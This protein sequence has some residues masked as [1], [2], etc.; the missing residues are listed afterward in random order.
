M[1][2]RIITICLYAVLFTPLLIW[3]KFLFPFITPKTIYFRCL[4]EIALFFY[5]L[6]I[7]KY[8]QYRPRLNPL[9][10]AVLIYVFVITIASIFGVN[11]YRSFWG[12][13]ERGEGLLTIYHIIIFFILL[14]ALFK[15]KK[16]WLRFFDISVLVSLLVSL[17]ALAQKLNFS[18]VVHPG[19]G[20][21]MSTIGNPSFVAAYLL[22]NI[23]LCLLLY[24]NKKDIQWRT[25]YGA[26][27]FFEI[28]ILFNTQ[29]RGALLGL[30]GGFLLLA[31]LNVIF[32]QN[33]KVKLGFVGLIL[34]L[35]IL[36]GSVWL[37]RN[38]AWVRTI[39]G[40][41][42]LA[43]ISFEDITTQS[44]LLAWRTS[45]Q[46]WQDRFWFGYGYENYNIAFN[47][48]FPVLIYR[49]PGSQ[50]WFDRAHNIIFD[51]AVTNGIFG[52]LAYLCIFWV[53]LWILWPKLK[54]SF[55]AIILVCLL[56]AYFVQNFFVFDVLASYITFYSVLGF[57][58]Y[59]AV[60]LPKRE[61]D[62]LSQPVGLTQRSP[63]IFIV[64]ILILCLA[65]TLHFFNIRL[66]WANHYCAKGLAYAYA[67]NYKESINQFK[68]ALEHPNS[69]SPETRQHLV[70]VA[71]QAV[72]SEQLTK[73][74]KEQI[75]HYAISE[76]QKNIQ[77]SPLDAYGYLFL[78]DIYNTC[79]I[80]N[81]ER[82]NLVI[83]TGEQALKLSPTRPQIYFE[84]GQAAINLG[85]VGEGLEYFRKGVELNP[86]VI[87]SHW[88]LAS[89]YIVTGQDELAE[90]EF[91]LMQEMG[92]NYYSMQNLNRLVRP[93]LMVKNYHKLVEIYQEMIKLEPN[94][95]DHYARL[96]A[97]YK[98]IGEIAKARETVKK[99][100]ELNPN[101]A[102][103]AEMFLELLEE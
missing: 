22:L 3:S 21:L 73:E 56:A 18:F 2:K 50:I 15:T 30:F 20:R 39:P 14:T 19:E 85:R 8:P 62:S 101:L 89:A 47:K 100:V 12:N 88:N 36:A 60:R 70:Q 84:M 45:W 95:A 46:G 5:L 11:L 7:I 43:E 53:G 81:P 79:A 87:E 63:G 6:L 33:K 25:Y 51:Q 77:A 83:Q 90:Q 48:Y 94:N 40:I 99:A 54:K 34:I 26:V 13:V 74:E 41:S 10:W 28:F 44:R 32:S 49:D 23:F 38:Q 67:D 29:T 69:Q 72:R 58:G 91:V 98:E 1:L 96:A 66:A 9:T 68:K 31:L 78:M 42:R 93:Y 97:S 57:I 24:L 27:F 59:L 64:F 75:C 76:I 37:C 52:L 82:L 17:Y 102:E 92:F 4:V 35:I 71:N 65:F 80:L 86:E 103:E 55:E 61:L 16:D